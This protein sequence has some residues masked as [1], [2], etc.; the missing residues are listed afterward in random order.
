MGTLADIGGIGWYSYVVDLSLSFTIGASLIAIFT[1]VAR[2]MYT[3]SSEGVAPRSWARIHPRY[4]TPT[5]ALTHA[6]IVWLVAIVGMTIVSDTP[7]DTFGDFI[8]DMSGYPLLLVYM[9]VAAAALRYQWR[10]RRAST[11]TVV[12]ALGIAG[13]AYVLY[14]NF[15]PLPKWPSNLAAGLFVGVTVAICVI[16]AVLRRRRS[17]VLARI[18]SSVESDAA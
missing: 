17:P 16:Y 8:G 15:D 10:R 14:E 3:M 7:L 1:W 6:G 13:M 18:G 5:T 12:G 4:Q 11:W 2:F 9:L